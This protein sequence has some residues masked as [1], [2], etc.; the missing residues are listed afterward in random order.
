V[1]RRLSVFKFLTFSSNSETS[2]LSL[3][4]YKWIPRVRENR[5][6]ISHLSRNVVL[7]KEASRRYRMFHLGKYVRI[8][9]VYLSIILCSSLHCLYF[10]RRIIEELINDLKFPSQKE[11]ELWKIFCHLWHKYEKVKQHINRTTEESKKKYI[12]T[13]I[14]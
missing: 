3:K 4:V 14:Y 10:Y 8:C 13:Y 2:F 9:I 11:R 7:C 1:T 5:R 6:R 12:Y